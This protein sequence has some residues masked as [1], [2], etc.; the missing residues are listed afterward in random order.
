MLL[1]PTTYPAWGPGDVN[2]V[3]NCPS[4][5]NITGH[6]DI[7]I[8][9]AG[10]IVDKYGTPVEGASV[11]LLRSKYETEGG[12]YILADAYKHIAQSSKNTSSTIVTGADGRFAWDVAPGVV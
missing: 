5:S 11:E 3:V 6:F 9:P 12:E 4:G 10:I 1:I 8:D 7:Y 2:Y